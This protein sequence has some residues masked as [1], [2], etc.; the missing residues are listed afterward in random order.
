MIAEGHGQHVNS[1]E[2]DQFCRDN[3][4]LGW[5]ETSAKDNSN[6]EEAT[7]HLIS[8]ILK[9]E[10]ENADNNTGGN[11]ENTGVNLDHHNSQHSSNNNP[12]CC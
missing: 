3:D 1:G 10:E 9:L 8:A 2:L 11:E 7:R 5:F 12:G 4:F 6:I